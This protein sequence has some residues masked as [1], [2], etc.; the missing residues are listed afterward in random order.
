MKTPQWFENY[1]SLLE[2]QHRHT[3]DSLCSI[4]A[5]IKN[6]KENHLAH[7]DT[8]LT[9][10]DTNQTWL[11]KTY[12]VVVSAAVGSFIAAIIS[13]IVTLKS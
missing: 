13:A 8:K 2:S 3:K 9:E 1:H 7:L 10:I 5:D 11:M 4:K 6:L 12:W